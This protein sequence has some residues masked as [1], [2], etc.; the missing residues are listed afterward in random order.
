MLMNRFAEP[1]CKFKLAVTG[2]L[3]VEVAGFLSLLCF[4]LKSYGMCFAV[5][6]F[7]GI[8]ESFLQTN[9]GALIG[10]VF[11]GQVE[12]YSVYRIIFSLGVTLTI[13]LNIALKGKPLWIFLTLVMMVQVLISRV[14]IE[15]SKH[16][17]AAGD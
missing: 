9:L 2:T 16:K 7:W 1:Y 14:S 4:F 8:S 3:I 15:L 13:I 12:S 17:L 11:P 5:S 6:V 10:K